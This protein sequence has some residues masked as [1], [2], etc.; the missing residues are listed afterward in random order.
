MKL[1]S[2]RVY[3]LLDDDLAFDTPL[4][5]RKPLLVKVISASKLLTE[6]NVSVVGLEEDGIPLSQYA[7][8]KGLK[9]ASEKQRVLFNREYN[10]VVHNF[11]EIGREL[12]WL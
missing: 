2:G 8:I 6:H 3:V 1:E 12:Y 5:K 9:P 7:S 10:K 11:K 4:A